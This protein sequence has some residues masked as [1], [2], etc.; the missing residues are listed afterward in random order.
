MLF[1]SFCGSFLVKMLLYCLKETAIIDQFKKLFGNG[2]YYLCMC[3]RCFDHNIYFHL[4]VSLITSIID[5]IVPFKQ[6]YS[7]L[8]V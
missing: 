2:K 1:F 4:I 7:E 3:I 6:N 5:N 8:Y